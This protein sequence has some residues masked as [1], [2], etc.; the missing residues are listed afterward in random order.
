MENH[1]NSLIAMKQVRIYRNLHKK[2]YSV[3]EK[4]H[5]RWK[6]VKHTNDINLRNVCFKVSE[7]GRQRVLS[8]KRKNVHAFI[9]G[10]LFPFAPKTPT[11]CVEVTY[12][13]YAS[14][15]FTAKSKNKHLDKAKFVSIADGKVTAWFP[16][17]EGKYI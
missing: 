13:P 3:Q 14:P 11:Q 8:E 6:V 17:F 10:E 7:T 16:E 9:I 12:N 15:L 5:G 1:T 4:V 2:L